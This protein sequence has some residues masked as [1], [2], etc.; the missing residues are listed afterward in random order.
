MRQCVL[1]YC[2]LSCQEAA[3]ALLNV[4]VLVGYVMF[5]TLHMP[6]TIH[7][8]QKMLEKMVMF[9]DSVT[10]INVGP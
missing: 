3:A 10:K 6:P 5:S 9:E 7:I 4:S 8:S 1:V 2:C